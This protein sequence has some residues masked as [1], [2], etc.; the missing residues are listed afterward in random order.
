[1]FVNLSHAPRRTAEPPSLLDLLGEC[2]QR[3]RHFIG[4]SCEVAR[5]RD[6]PAAEVSRACADAARYFSEALPLH[7]AD[8]EES[9]TPHLRDRSPAVNE[10]LDTSSA[11]H[12][13]HAAQIE[14][15]LRALGEVG[16]AP[17][18]ESARER[19]ASIAAPLRTELEEHLALEERGIFPVIR[20]M[21]AETQ[22]LIIDELRARRR[23]PP[24]LTMNEAN[25]R[26]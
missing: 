5:R 11:Q 16:R 19:L 20:D 15:L 8:E 3:I 4:L 2:H 6:T 1:M 26:G 24:L 21:P 10:A 9:I 22:A 18:D 25:E 14:L 13:W 17:L 12:V 23:A 7:V